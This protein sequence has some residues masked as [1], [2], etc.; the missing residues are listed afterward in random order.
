[1]DVI[2]NESGLRNRTP[3]DRVTLCSAGKHPW[4]ALTR[5][6]SQKMRSYRYN[7]KRKNIVDVSEMDEYTPQEKKKLETLNDCVVKLTETSDKKEKYD[8]EAIQK[9]ANEVFG[10]ATTTRQSKPSSTQIKRCL[11]ET[12]GNRCASTLS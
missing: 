4:S 12:F 2:H 6:L 5:C 10:N 1:M 7:L 9:E 3:S 8:Y 11:S